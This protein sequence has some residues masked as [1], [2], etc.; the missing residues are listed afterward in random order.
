M[1]KQSRRRH[2]P[3]HVH[4][5]SAR[6][7]PTVHNPHDSWEQYDDGQYVV[8]TGGDEQPIIAEKKLHNG[9][10]YWHRILSDQDKDCADAPGVFYHDLTGYFIVRVHFGGDKFERRFRSKKKARECVREL[11]QSKKKARECVRELV[12]LVSS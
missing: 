9:R 3:V 5:P 7:R 8:L 11:T 12:D 4:L 10:Y 2:F 6:P 1:G